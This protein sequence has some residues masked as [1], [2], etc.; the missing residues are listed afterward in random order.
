MDTVR[1]MLLRAALLFPLCFAP[2][3]FGQATT[4]KELNVSFAPL[5]VIKPILE[6]VLTPQGK[7][8]M[9]ANKGAVLVI[10]TPEGILAAE[11]A[12]AGA[13][14]PPAD[15]ALDFQFVTGLPTRRTS[16]TMAQEVP[17]PVEFAPP[18]IFVGGGRVTGFVPA[19]PTKFQTRNIGV[20]SESVSTRNPDG[21]V[22]LDINTES[23]AFDGFINY[24][25]AIL[26]AGAIGTVPVN[27]L[28]GDPG[29]FS[30][31]VNT[32]GISLPIISTTRISTSIVIRPRL[33]AGVVNL[34]MMPRLQVVLDGSQMEPQVVDLK[35]FHTSVAVPNNEV[36]RV[37]GFTG[38]D[39]DFNR[40]F[41]GAKDPGSG[42]TAVVVKAR[43]TPPKPASAPVVPPVVP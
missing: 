40:R 32:G 6:K 23:T 24:G 37:Y 39:D 5:E 4:K 8:L 33:E 28:V 38:A 41:F 42:G 16:I 12:I 2:T 29:F 31:F 17:F 13:Q 27:G 34:D 22:T 14:L 35:Q 15:I 11:A 25:S 36:A 3:A 30:P 1:L 7:F 9:L 21:S 26:P 10:D 19:T 43:A 18:T 20:T